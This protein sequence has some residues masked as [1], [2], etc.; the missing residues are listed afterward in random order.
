MSVAA[1]VRQEIDAARVG[2]WF[3]VQEVA[4]RHGRRHAVE[5]ALTRAAHRGDLVPI[6]RG[7]YW[8]G[9]KTRF[10][11]TA[12]DAL[13]AALAAARAAGFPIGVGPAGWTASHVLGLSTQIPALVHVAVPGRP[14]KAPDGVKFHQRA[15]AGRAGLGVLDVALLEVL[16]TFPHMVQSDWDA[17]VRRV[18][19]LAR[20][21]RIDAVAVLAAAQWERR[22]GMRALADDLG[23]ALQ[24]R[25]T[26][27]AVC[28]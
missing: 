20:E 10:G 26:G 6:K 25:R 27:P 13:D 18:E 3:T 8:K 4:A 16:R 24:D 23:Q 11:T 5:L 19:T 22:P 28:A 21:G 7:L 2:D 9:A 12:P 1:A 15:P 17:V 14:P